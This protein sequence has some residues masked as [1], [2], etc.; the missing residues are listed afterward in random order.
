VNQLQTDKL[1]RRALDEDIGFGDITTELTPNAA[2]QISAEFVAKSGGVLC[3]SLIAGRCFELYCGARTAFSRSDGDTLDPRISFGTVQGPGGGILTAERVALNFLQRLSGIATQARRLAERAKPHGI[4]IVETR[5][6]TP[7][8]RMLEKYAVRT[9]TGY[10]HRLRLDDC[11]MIKDNHFAL[12]G[13]DPAELVRSIKARAGHTLKLIA[14]AGSIE[15]V[16]PLAEAGADVVL[17]DNFTPEDVRRG[18]GLVD[19]RALIELS[20]GINEGNLDDYLIDGVDVISIGA[21]T[22]SY[23]ALDISLEA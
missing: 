19:G 10:N 13:G 23:Q 16:Q 6:T 22:H 8:L 1:I 14:E 11:M 17:F 9:G 4:R 5:K 21:L 15:M 20:G 2:Q 12:Y 18:V 7:G 3:G